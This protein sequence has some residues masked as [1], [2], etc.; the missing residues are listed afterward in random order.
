ML[1]MNFDVKV[2]RRGAGQFILSLILTAT[3]AFSPLAQ[4]QL[5]DP[6]DAEHPAAEVAAPEDPA[7]AFGSAFS[8]SWGVSMAARGLDDPYRSGRAEVDKAGGVTLIL[9]G[10]DGE[11]QFHSFEIEMQPIEYANEGAP[12]RPAAAIGAKKQF[13][14]HLKRLSE[15]AEASINAISAD[16]ITLAQKSPEL[17]FKLLDGVKAAGDVALRLPIIW[18]ETRP[19]R[20]RIRIGAEGKA[21]RREGVWDN[22]ETESLDSGGQTVWR[23]KVAV[24]D[25]IVV[26]DNQTVQKYPF[27]IDG[28]DAPRAG[29][30]GRRL[31][32]IG[33]NL[34]DLTKFGAAVRSPDG[35][36]E[37]TMDPNGV[38]QQD[39]RLMLARAMTDGALAYAKGFKK[40]NSRLVAKLEARRKGLA[41]VENLLPLTATLNPGVKPGFQPLLIDDARGSW[42]LLFANQ[43]AALQFS[44]Y[45]DQLRTTSV[46]VFYPGDIGAVDIIL[47][48]DIPFDSIGVRLLHR[49]IGAEDGEDAKE[50]AVLLARRL[51][52]SGATDELVFRSDPIHFTS[53]ANPQRRPPANEEAFSLNVLKGDKI[54]AQLLDPTKLNPLPPVV[55]AEIYLEP[56]ELGELWKSALQRVATCDG[57]AFDGD[58]LYALEKST[59][60]SEFTIG[61]LVKYVSPLALIYSKVMDSQES[62]IEFNPSVNV[63]KGDH[64]ALL[65]IRDE[66][67]KMMASPDIVDPLSALADNKNG[68]IQA[69]RAR[70]VKNGADSEPLIK[71]SSAN[72][73]AKPFWRQPTIGK[74]FNALFGRKR[75]GV[76][77]TENSMI[78]HIPLSQTLDIQYL[79]ERYDVPYAEAEAWAIKVTQGAAKNQLTNLNKAIGRAQDAGSCDV[80]ELLVVAGQKAGPVVDRIVP[81]LVMKVTQPG[82]PLAQYWQPDKIARFYV[83][84]VHLAGAAV[85]ALDQY[86]V[87]DDGYKAMGLAVLT[88]GAAAGATVGLSGGAA[89]GAGIMIAGDA[90]D[91]AYF[92]V[93]GLDRAIESQDFYD[94]ARGAS[95][96]LGDEILIEAEAQRESVEMALIGLI[97]PAIGAGLGV[98]DLRN[99]KNINKGRALI[100]AKGAA[101]INELDTLTDLERTHLAAY[102]DDT[103]AKTKTIGLD[104]LDE[105]DRAAMDS[106][107]RQTFAETEPWAPAGAGVKS[108][109]EEATDNSKTI[110]LSSN[111]ADA[112]LTT[113]NFPNSVLDGPDTFRDVP[114]D[115]VEIIRD[116]IQPPREYEILD[117][118]L[119]AASD[120]P[121]ARE[122]TDV[123][124]PHNPAGTINGSQLVD[125]EGN[126]IGELG[127][128]IDSGGFSRIY[129]DP[130]DEGFIKRVTPLDTNPKHDAASVEK[131]VFEDAVGRKLLEDAEKGSNY[132]QVTKQ[133]GKPVL[134]RDENGNRFLV[135]TETNIAKEIDGKVVTNAKDRFANRPPTKAE[136]MTMQLAIRELNQKGI[137][138]T[139][140]K[141]INFDI[142]PSKTSP[143]GHRMVFFD[144]G[145]IRPMKGATP[146]MRWRNARQWQQIIDPPN[147]SQMALIR[148]L[149]KGYDDA[150]DL[151]S[152]GNENHYAFTLGGNRG[153]DEYLRLNNLDPAQFRAEVDA[154]SQQLGREIVYAPPGG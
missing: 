94:Y 120:S 35:A 3:L 31:I 6:P 132:L 76:T 65:L 30:K 51:K 39:P 115:D 143:T 29:A 43:D 137:L 103:L 57:D 126:V 83:E 28:S 62:Q 121:F 78:D 99:F 84:R 32:V 96:I 93:K 116:A 110:G 135:S 4:A 11:E 138:W 66:L 106:L 125:S 118:Q 18:A 45:D 44:R 26:V 73:I 104:A 119:D 36:I 67:V 20:L 2:L 95:L 55:L 140:H 16:L 108:S 8:G 80:E 127:D 105:T 144:P 112:E 81:R 151:R 149:A 122:I 113:S 53:F 141:M 42:P 69:L 56:A 33:E 5:D 111:N 87:I 63:Y 100:K 92:G 123:P 47:K 139:D 25:D 75:G 58:P 101:I 38:S 7:A 61:E 102:L 46:P 109:S 114:L 72:W 24:I 152:F 21:S 145:G 37:Y 97:A 124:D 107:Y 89:V 131:V 54:G 79:A 49:S 147:N 146:E 86:S 82:P 23:R 52:D 70:A 98:K 91:A 50:V 48:A 74:A 88:A 41:S 117:G 68:E 13:T 129:K 9:E 71:H 22:A 12:V 34:R 64:A 150:V 136:R 130:D 134:V 59:R 15:N 40:P 77:S 142:V 1:K 128:F 17:E 27:K 153:R 60:F 19:D 154:L 148:K 133:K 10:S 14:I 85:R 90:A